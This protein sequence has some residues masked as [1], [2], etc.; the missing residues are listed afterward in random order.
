MDAINHCVE[1]VR[2]KETTKEKKLFSL[3]DGFLCE[4]KSTAEAGFMRQTTYPKSTSTAACAL[5]I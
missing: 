1:G 3:R 2:K 5:V 4:I